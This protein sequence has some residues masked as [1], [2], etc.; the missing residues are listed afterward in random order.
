[1]LRRVPPS[2]WLLVLLALAAA[3]PAAALEDAPRFR[4]ITARE[5]LSQGVVNDVL[6]DREGFVWLATQ[7]GL[8]RYDGHRIRVF[9]NDP[10]DP[11]TVGGNCLW[12]L[13]E[14]SQGRIWYGTEGAGFGCFDPRQETFVN[15]R[16]DPRA[17]ASLEAYEVLDL[18]V[19]A[20]DRIWLAT[21]EHGLL[22]F[23][24]AD[25]TLTAWRHDP[26]SATGLPSDEVW[27][28]AQTGDGRIWAGTGG[29][30]CRIDPATGQVERWVHAED[31][32][33]SLVNDVVYRLLQDRAGRLWVGTTKGLD[34]YDPESD[35]FRHF[36]NDP[37]DP[38][39]L[40]K[41]SIGGIAEDP[42]GRMWIA[43]MNGGLN[44][45]EPGTGHCRHI[46]HD[47]LVPTSLGSDRL[48][49][50]TI[51]RSGLLWVS[52][53]NGANLLDLNAKRFLH[54]RPG[55]AAEG[56]LSEPTVWT[57]CEDGYGEVWVGTDRGLNRI[58]PGQD[59]VQV[60][61]HDEAD[62]TSVCADGL[63]AVYEDSHGRLWVASDRGGLGWYDREGD[64]FV[65]YRFGPEAASGL[66]HNRV[67]GLS[68]DRDGTLW[69][70]TMGGLHHYDRD[71]DVF[72]P[73][74]PAGASGR[75]AALRAVHADSRG[76]IW[77][78][79][80]SERLQ[81]FDPQSGAYIA[82][83]HDPQ[84]P[85]SPT[86][87]TVVCFAEDNHGQVW[88]G[89][90][91]GLNR[92][93]EQ[94]DDF[95]RFGV[96]DGLPNAT[97]YGM[98]EDDHGRLWISTNLGLSRFTPATGVFDNYDVSDGLQDN[99]FNSQSCSR[100]PGGRMYFGGINGLTVFRP[101]EIRNSRNRPRVVIT[102]L[103]LANRSLQPGKSAD[104]RV[105]LDRPPHL[106]ERVVLGHGDEVLTLE[107]SALDFAAPGAARYAYRLDG[108]DE[109]WHE[110]GDRHHATYTS[111]PPGNYLFRARATN[112]DGIWS[113]FEAR[114]AVV[115]T[116]PFW[117]TA[118]FLVTFVLTVVALVAGIH[119]WRTGLI[120]RR[121]RELQRHVSLRTADLEQEILERRRAEAE[122]LQA[123]E[124]AVAA[125]RAKSEFLANMSHEIRTPLNG[126]IGLTGA[127]LD[128][129]LSGEQREFCEM[130]QSSAN[131][132]LIVINDVLDFSK[133]EAGKLEIETVAT[134]PRDV[135]DDVADMLALQAWDKGLA[136]TT[137]VDPAVPAVLPADPGRLRQIL[138]NL[139]GN[140]VKF[141][142]RGRIEV[143]LGLAGDAGGPRLRWEVRDTGIGI[144]AD[145]RDRLFQS[146]SQL[147]TS[148]TRRYGGTGLGLAI[149]RQLVELMGGA[150]GCD[151]RPGQ[152]SIFWFETPLVGAARAVP[153]RREG[154]VL[155]IHHDEGERASLAAM[156][157]HAGYAHGVVAEQHA[158][159]EAL[160]AAAAAGEPYLAV[161][162][163]AG[164]CAEAAE[165][166]AG[167]AR[168]PVLAATRLVLLAAPGD[169]LDHESYQ[170]L[171]FA[172]CLGAPV[173][174]RRLLEAL[175]RGDFIPPVPRSGPDPQRGLAGHHGERP[176]LLL[177][178][179]N[180][181][182]QRVAGL[183]LDKLGYD[184]DVVASGDA[185][186]RALRERRY[187]AVLMDVQ[188][189]GMDGLEAARLIRDPAGGVLEPAVPI[190][191]MTAHA[192]AS[193]RERCLAAGMDDHVTKPVE[194]AALAE[195]L[196]RLTAVRS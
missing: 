62:S 129:T 193:D 107:F 15:F 54:V 187:A 41:S 153:A 157:A 81:R 145:K 135:I 161:V 108:F 61:L 68:E 67:F 160:G 175:E 104:G 196:A 105:I 72:V 184:H 50:L 27:C 183:I 89:T 8:N 75:E 128:T 106:S 103:Q 134:A 64:R 191:A 36:R 152:G 80:W 124:D 45:L 158:G 57:V 170:R 155:V 132:L 48:S 114:L 12:T 180:P 173:K 90:T 102:D 150:I 88:I 33:T 82:W 168:D 22:H 189:P 28:V 133:I 156:L 11:A 21:S 96:R 69:L 120:R 18:T 140:A 56:R 58:V 55:K 87:N 78:G 35:G 171:G 163:G 23:D 174:H 172:E 149:S 117:Q 43:S 118:W 130:A 110:I 83:Q 52:S 121:N 151:S 146:F 93:D 111:L 91:N 123:K 98:L 162:L 44:L 66:L 95:E 194:S 5:G 37:D 59:T 14:D 144:A 177:A 112:H 19:D 6:Q 141:T 20:Q 154:R 60:Y 39:S 38:H 17:P 190:V 188:M 73:H 77:V 46:R 4:R 86:S 148:T 51:D 76:R 97:I 9:Q 10:D 143:R 113:P 40:A 122:L 195:V 125:T 34:L 74:L 147:D 138:L 165:F 115:V 127:L 119:Q 131:A 142:A 169:R 42:S 186:V 85:R 101:D 126:V 29:G 7:D 179:D 13:G 167:L 2:A 47:P 94:G 176:R 71:R 136:F 164:G 185:A 24:P 166:A 26:A 31:D 30:L 63:S 139:T 53:Q 159:R 178:E 32:S 79:T 182:N 100:G 70:A 99:E 137:W 84:D 109:D 181:I 49:N 16:W 1:M 92:Y 192:M 3:L 116:P 65:N 25:S